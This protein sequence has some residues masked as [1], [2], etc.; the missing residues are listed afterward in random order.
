MLSN[1]LI[2]R[3]KLLFRKDKELYLYIQE[4]TGYLPHNIEYYKQALMHRSAHHISVGGKVC[5][6]ERLEFL[7]DAILDA[8]IGDIVYHHFPGKR[9]GFLTNTRAK[10]VSRDNL[11]KLA[12]QIGLDKH[13]KKGKQLD[14]KHNSYMCGNAFEALVGALYLDHGYEACMRFLRKHVLGEL[15]NIDKLAYKEVNFK[16]KMIEWAQK[17]KKNVVFDTVEQRKEQDG[18]PVFHASVVIDG[19]LGCDGLGYSKK[20]SHQEAARK[21]L[22]RLKKDSDFLKTVLAGNDEE[23]YQS[24]CNQ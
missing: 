22:R 16:S 14:H 17:N 5:H 12:L 4:T 9:E 24:A 23:Q 15:I 2:D 10:I 21:T 1:T 3:V 18:S 8:S 20:E 7:G 13:I 6:N 19:V 11:N